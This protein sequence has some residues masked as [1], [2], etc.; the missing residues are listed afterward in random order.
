[1]RNKINSIIS[2]I[3][4]GAMLALTGCGTT[5]AS[6]NKDTAFA[7]DFS[8]DDK[9][10]DNG[11]LDVCHLRHEATCGHSL[12]KNDT[13][14]FEG[15]G[16]LSVKTSGAKLTY[17]VYS[18]SPNLNSGMKNVYFTKDGSSTQ[19]SL[20]AAKVKETKTCDFAQIAAKEKN[21]KG[22][23]HL[24]GV[25]ENDY[26]VCMNFW[27][28]GTEIWCCRL[29]EDAKNS[30]AAWNKVVGKLDP[31]KCLSFYVN[32]DKKFPIT[33]P[34]NGCDGSV[35]HV[36]EWR[37]LAHEIILHDTWSD[38]AKVFALVEWFFRNTAYDDWRV[39][40]NDNHSRAFTDN[41]WTKDSY[42]MF[43]NHVG[44]CWDYANAMTIMCRELGIPCTTVDNSNHA[45]N[46]VWL[47]DEWVC[48]DISS[49]VKYRCVREDTNKKYWATEKEH[50]FCDRYG[51][52]STLFD[53]VNQGLCTPTTASDPDNGKNPM[54]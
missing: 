45:A 11:R 49:L 54:Y 36:D 15:Y 41:A 1:M 39:K 34:T 22:I 32:D 23:W 20:G 29:I 16:G 48:I 17:T 26:Q 6:Y 43:Y 2:L 5:V 28:D 40:V 51:Y 44:Q 19:Y 33:Y 31:K 3:L 30:I 10:I 25:F 37:K 42:F 4:V 52:Y 53:A 7:G 27:F 24:N 46:A 21:A 50:N 13:I 38:E 12:W 14:D 35:V 47:N 9:I 18:H 8:S